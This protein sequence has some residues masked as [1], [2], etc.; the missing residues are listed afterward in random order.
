LAPSCCR[1]PDARFRPSLQDGLYALS[2]PPAMTSDVGV[3]MGRPC[4][5]SCSAVLLWFSTALSSFPTTC[6][7]TRRHLPA[8]VLFADLTHWSGR[9]FFFCFSSLAVSQTATIFLLQVCA[10]CFFFF[11]FFFFSPRKGLLGLIVLV[12]LPGR[13]AWGLFDCGLRQT[14]VFAGL[15]G[16]PCVL[17]WFHSGL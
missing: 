3:K 8:G 14:L 5:G 15:I 1:G 17:A 9:F 11:F 12:I 6:P 7:P 10:W 16:F 4:P 2:T 13:L